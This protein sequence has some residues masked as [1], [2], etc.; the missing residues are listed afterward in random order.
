MATETPYQRT[1][2][3]IAEALESEAIGLDLSGMELT[4]LPE[5]LGQLTQLQSL[6]LSHNQL[7]VLP[8]W[9][10]QLTQLQ[11]LILS[12]N[13]LTALPEWLGYL[14][15]LRSLDLSGNQLT[16]LPE[17]LGQLTQL[18]SLILSNN[19][20]TVLPEWL[21]QLTQLQ[22]LN[23][24]GNQLT[25]LSESLDH[26]ELLIEL[27][28]GGNQFLQ[29]P[30]ALRGLVHLKNLLIHAN[31]IQSVP[32]WICELRSL[33]EM[34]I[35][36]AQLQNL[37]QSFGDLARLKTL[38]LGADTRGNPIRVFPQCLQQLKG[39]TNLWLNNCELETVPLWLSDL[40]KLTKLRLG[41][42]KIADLPAS[43]DKLQQLSELDLSKNPLNPE[44]AAAYEQGLD[45][46]KA[47]LREKAKGTRQRYEAKLLILGDGNEGKT[48]VSR[49]LRGLTFEKQTTTRGV[50]VEPWAF[51][52]PNYPDDEDCQIT[53][54][55][56]DF[57]GQEINHQT[58]QFFL[59]T[60]SLYL[61]VFKCRDQ[62]LLDRAEYWLDT[63]RSR[64]PGA[65]V[66]IVITECEQ[67]TPYIPQDRLQTEYGD[68]LIGDPWLF[69]VGC[70]DNSG[71]V[72]LQQALQRR[73]A[74]LPFMGRD[75]PQTYEKA[76]NQI[77]SQAKNTSHI[78]RSQLH[79]IFADSNIDT[80]GYDEAAR[81]LTRLGFIT[82]FEDRPDL[83][84]FIVL[85]PQWLTKAISYVMEDRQLA[86]DQG[87]IT[88]KRMKEIWAGQGQGAMFS[89]F[90]N[91]MK[92]F[93]LCYDLENYPSD[94]C[95]VPLRF[96]Y[97]QPDIP[98][99]TGEQ[100]KTR[101][102]TYRLNLR[103]PTGLMSRFI[104]KTNHMIVRAAADEASTG[105]RGVYWHNG[106]FL[107]SGEGP[108]LSQ[109]LCQF[110][111]E[112]R[113]LSIEVRAA[114]PQKL[115]DQIDAYVR[116]VFTFFQGLK[117]V[118]SYGCITVDE[119]AQIETQC[120]ALHTER[121]ILFAIQNQEKLSC[122]EGWHKVDPMRL[123]TGVGSFGGD[124]KEVIREEAERIQASVRDEGAS[125]RAKF[126]ETLEPLIQNMA[127]LLH[128][129]DRHQRA[130][131]QLQDDRASL[132]PEI[133]QELE[134]KLREYL[135]HMSDM[136]DE[137][138]QR[139]A[140]SLFSIGTQDGNPWN[141]QTYFHQTY[142]L[143]PWCEWERGHAPPR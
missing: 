126:A 125:T 95:L 9:L 11:S 32:S 1:E 116:A 142:V 3:E 44:L 2:S 84:D 39:L 130:L 16:A 112:S 115:L 61:L 25:D 30:E 131:Q 46:V 40:T 24:Y 76:E 89:I 52:H 37:P 114:F 28:I 97:R 38:L 14:T 83:T 102:V 31:A 51:S 69:A 86:N 67:R 70:A 80:A 36:G 57:E 5:V 94:R 12:N 75:W 71:I 18:Q 117:P 45:S 74:D 127:T 23:L 68:L 88:F 122:E 111:A 20:L 119:A 135:G 128:W 132:A 140:P 110:N 108:L 15:Q 49:A 48:C 113:T 103:P 82:Q 100:C 21:G 138:H 66:T 8:E 65:Q 10:G 26:I 79:Q 50:D 106:V 141:P 53:L 124:I 64:A 134:L 13:R 81:S 17:S 56:W 43:L 29:F 59:S 101:R 54:N 136:L 109:A 58:H 77:K 107:Q 60:D 55:L 63:I 62:F 93:E 42:N 34:T 91:C 118:R 41:N 90:H 121:K 72:E 96:G 139:S 7:T 33:E 27:N 137:R 143:T 92:E 35:V 123:I 4:E 87:E 104:V 22:S 98:W 85:Q 133:R 129:A 78:T 105:R 73:A 120:I 19:R 99:T 47:Y 6:D